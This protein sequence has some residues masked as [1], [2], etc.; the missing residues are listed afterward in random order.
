MARL[1][2]TIRDRF[3]VQ[4]RGL[5]PV[6]GIEP[7]GNERFCIGDR[8]LL[9]RPD[10]SILQTTIGGLELLDPNPNH[11]VVVLQGIDE[12]RCSHRH[13]SLVGRSRLT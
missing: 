5:V 1:L 9:R 2:F 7:Q 11:D 6:P 12:G 4:G 13:R 8:L 10:G 3:L